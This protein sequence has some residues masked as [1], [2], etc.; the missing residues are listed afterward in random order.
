VLRI[1]NT[2]DVDRVGQVQGFLHGQNL[3]VRIAAAMDWTLD[4]HAGDAVYRVDI[5]PTRAV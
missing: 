2:V 4:F 5:A 3:L 1:A